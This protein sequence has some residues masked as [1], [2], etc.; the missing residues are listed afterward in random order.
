MNDVPSNSPTKYI[1]PLPPPGEP[2]DLDALLESKPFKRW[3]EGYLNGWAGAVVVVA[4]DRA[5][6]DAV[7]D[8]V[9]DLAWGGLALYRGNYSAYAIQRAERMALQQVEYER[10]Q[11]FIDRTE[12]FI[13]RHMAGRP[14]AFNTTFRMTS[15]LEERIVRVRREYRW[16][17]RICNPKE[18]RARRRSCLALHCKRARYAQRAQILRLTPS[19]RRRLALLAK[20]Q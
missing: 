1:C 7:V 18:R 5:F 9:W 4:H 6:L 3:L 12:E 10:Q 2:V 13:R 17:R 14:Y 11:Q 16:L 8:R 19:R 15:S 20:V